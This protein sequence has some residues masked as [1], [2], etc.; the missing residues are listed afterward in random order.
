M[1]AAVGENSRD[2][3]CYAADAGCG[4]SE[5]TGVRGLGEESALGRVGI[6]FCR[7]FIGSRGSGLVPG[8]R[9]VLASRSSGV[10]LSV[11]SS[12]GIDLGAVP[13]LLSRLERLGGEL[14]LRAGVV[15]VGL[16]RVLGRKRG[17]GGLDGRGEGVV[18]GLGDPLLV[19]GDG[20]SRRR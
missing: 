20:R 17:L 3:G 2:R 15:Y 5:Q 7:G 11:S 8:L 14:Q 19:G 10:A 1:H 4:S 6:R 16:L 18:V 13:G 9:T 12:I